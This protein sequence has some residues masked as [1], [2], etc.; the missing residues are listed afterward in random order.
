MAVAT[1]ISMELH[2]RHQTVTPFVAPVLFAAAALPG[3]ASIQLNQ[4]WASDI[5]AGAFMGVFSGYKVTRYS[6]DHPRNWFDRKL[7]D[8]SLSRGADG[9]FLVGVNPF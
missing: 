6:H 5:L 7:L 8:V 2:E 3:L 9:R 4:H 1:V